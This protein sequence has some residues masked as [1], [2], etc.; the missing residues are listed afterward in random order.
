MSERTAAPNTLVPGR[1]SMV[2]PAPASVARTAKSPNPAKRQKMA[3]LT[4][5]R[6]DFICLTLTLLL[7]ASCE[8]TEFLD[9]TRED[10]YCSAVRL[11]L[12]WTTRRLQTTKKYVQAISI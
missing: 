11:S 8:Y 5:L 2:L 4:T 7:K 9:S 12:L 6:S 10:A 3:I 1:I